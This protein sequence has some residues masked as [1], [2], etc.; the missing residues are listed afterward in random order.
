VIETA[1][2][3]ALALKNEQWAPSVLALSRQ[4]L[5]QLRTDGSENAVGQGRLPLKAPSKCARRSC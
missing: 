3:W 4:N 5:P 1:E 2:C